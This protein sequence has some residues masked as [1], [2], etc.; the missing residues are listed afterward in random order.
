MAT[1]P[2]VLYRAP[3]LVV[4]T[5]PTKAGI[6][7][8]RLRGHNTLTGAVTTAATDIMFEIDAG[9][10]WKS[11]SVLAKGG[12]YPY[13][14]GNTRGHAWVAF[15]PDDFYDPTTAAVD[16]LPSDAMF[17]Y[18][19]VQEF[20][21][22]ANAYLAEER[23]VFIVPPAAF[24]GVPNPS[25]TMTVDVPQTTATESELE[26]QMPPV[27]AVKI[28]FPGRVTSGFIQNLEAETLYYSVGGNTPMIRIPNSG[29]ANL[30][31]GVSDEICLA[32]IAAGGCKVSGLFGLST[33]G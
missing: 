14:P 22:A 7:K 8:F 16:K 20:S 5:F 18:Y 12:T 3:N 32:S 25:I 24:W 23:R 9:A 21:I 4:M 26:G 29:S 33:G 6:S 15:D 10:H 28:H 19:T 2:S 17:A 30:F 1:I 11:S 13:M 31:H 27:A